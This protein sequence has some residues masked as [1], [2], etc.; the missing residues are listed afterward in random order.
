MLSSFRLYYVQINEVKILW[1]GLGGVRVGAVVQGTDMRARGWGPNNPPTDSAK[2]YDE[3]SKSTNHL[4]IANHNDRNYHI[5]AHIFALH[6]ISFASISTGG[7]CLYQLL[8]LIIL[9]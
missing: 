8:R 7:L 4:V 9:P 1:G 5:F 3:V 6:R 2:P